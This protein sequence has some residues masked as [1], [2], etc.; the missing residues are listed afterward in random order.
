MRRCPTCEGRGILPEKVAA[1]VES[2]YV[3]LNP[4]KRSGQPCINGTRIPTENWAENVWA[5][6]EPEWLASLFSVQGHVFTRADVLVACWYMGEHGGRA[7]QKRWREWARSVHGE[8]WH[9][10]YDVPDPPSRDG[11]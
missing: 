4:A 6:D 3:S 9:G 1:A 7:W 8:L 10:R 2:P 11:S 5:G